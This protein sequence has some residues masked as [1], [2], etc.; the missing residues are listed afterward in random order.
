MLLPGVHYD[1]LVR[2]HHMLWP[3][4]TVRRPDDTLQA[5]CWVGEYRPGCGLRPLLSQGA[6]LNLPLVALGVLP[7]AG[8]R[9]PVGTA[10][11]ERVRQEFPGGAVRVA[12]GVGEMVARAAGHAW[13][14][15]SPGASW[16][17]SLALSAGR[18]VLAAQEHPER[19]LPSLALESPELWGAEGVAGAFR[20]LQVVAP[21]AR[22]VG[23]ILFGDD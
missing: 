20:H 2:H 1:R 11:V 18:P 19:W 7:D 16:G 22:A 21:G 17:W 13:T 12:E 5:L 23:E 6:R 3:A 14:T 9:C 10:Y 15:F 4:R 8:G